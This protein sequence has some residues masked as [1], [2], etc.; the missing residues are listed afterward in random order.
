MG[1]DEKKSVWLIKLLFRLGKK[2]LQQYLSR[3]KTEVTSSKHELWRHMPYDGASIRVR[4]TSS[5]CRKGQIEPRLSETRQITELKL[6][7]ITLSSVFAHHAKIGNNWAFGNFCLFLLCSSAW[8]PPQWLD[9][10]SL[11]TC[12]TT[13]PAN[14]KSPLESR[15]YPITFR[16][17]KTK[18]PIFASS[19]AMSMI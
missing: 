6:G 17:Q 1:I 16:Y 7:I 5:T 2:R 10:F 11:S 13:C 15:F 4:T 9:R 19:P 14:S 3:I 8:P 12:Q 18:S